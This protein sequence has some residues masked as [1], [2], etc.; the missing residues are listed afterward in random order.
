[1]ESRVSFT[2]A[3]GSGV[4]WSRWDVGR[5]DLKVDAARAPGQNASTE[6]TCEEQQL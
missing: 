4:W 1:M 3:G 6:S 5:D 2:E